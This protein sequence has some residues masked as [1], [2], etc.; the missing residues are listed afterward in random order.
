MK[1]EY[2]DSVRVRN[3]ALSKRFGIDAGG[4]CGFREVT[5]SEIAKR[6][7]V[8]VGTILVLVEGSE[9]VAVEIPEEFLDLFDG[10][11]GKQ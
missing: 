11:N 8:S 5:T 4:V 2:G 10:E 7:G 3:P 6:I 1:F 9:G